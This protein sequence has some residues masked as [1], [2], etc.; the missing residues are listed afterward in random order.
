MRKLTDLLREVVKEAW[1]SP[2][3]PQ[4]QPQRSPE[5]KPAVPLREPLIDPGTPDPS[6]PKKRR[7]LTP[8]KVAPATAPKA[9]S[10]SE[11]EDQVFK[12]ISSRFVKLKKNK[13]RT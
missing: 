5:K 10:I 1:E 11:T 6:G 8:P 4:P 9:E 7:T 12:K 2:F 3:S 13:S